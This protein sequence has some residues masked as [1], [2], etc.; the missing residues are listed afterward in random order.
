MAMILQGQHLIETGSQKRKWAVTVKGTEPRVKVLVK[1]F[2]SR[3][4]KWLGNRHH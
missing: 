3:G 4:N 2:T 1:N